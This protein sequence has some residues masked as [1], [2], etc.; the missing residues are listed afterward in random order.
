MSDTDPTELASTIPPPAVTEHDTG[1]VS[2]HDRIKADAAIAIRDAM[3]AHSEAWL[4][5]E[6]AQHKTDTALGMAADEEAA[7]VPT[8]FERLES[9][10]D[11]MLQAMTDLASNLVTVNQKVV[12]LETKCGRSCPFAKAE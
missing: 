6:L 3:Q 10:L 7:R 12:V 4:L 9:K 11:V 2:Q 5:L 1:P 8:R